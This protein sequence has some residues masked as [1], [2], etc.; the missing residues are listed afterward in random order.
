M[1][2]LLNAAESDIQ[3]RLNTEYIPDFAPE[4]TFLWPCFETWTGHGSDDC[5]IGLMCDHP[6]YVRSSWFDPPRKRI[7]IRYRLGA[8]HQW[9]LQRNGQEW[10]I[11]RVG[12]LMRLMLKKLSRE[13]AKAK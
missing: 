1:P 12:F 9:L 3:F 6:R 2:P 10:A 11:R 13:V 4:L 8:R 5:W 7:L